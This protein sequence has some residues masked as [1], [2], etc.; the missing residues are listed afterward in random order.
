[1]KS[2]AINLSFYVL[3]KWS[4]SFLLNRKLL[5]LEEK[6]SM[7]NYGIPKNNN[8]HCFLKEKDQDLLRK[9]KTTIE[10]FEVMDWNLKLI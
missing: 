3:C 6:V 2:A 4:K 5:E 8:F 9:S 1:M 7:K 10:N